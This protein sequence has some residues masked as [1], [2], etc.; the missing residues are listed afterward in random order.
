MHDK[1]RH[2]SLH[3]ASETGRNLFVL[4]Y[5]GFFLT[6]AAG[7]NKCKAQDTVAYPYPV[8]QYSFELERQP[9]SMA[10]MDVQDAKSSGRVALLLHGKNFNGYYWKEVIAML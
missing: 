4:L 5:F 3:P 6:C 2:S 1:N 7:S 9:V 10:Y 8:K